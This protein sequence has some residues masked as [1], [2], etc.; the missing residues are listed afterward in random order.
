MGA[1][2]HPDPTKWFGA[3]SR[4]A[5]VERQSLANHPGGGSGG[6]PPRKEWGT[7]LSTKPQFENP[8]AVRM[9]SC[10]NA[11]MICNAS[12]KTKTNSDVDSNKTDKT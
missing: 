7:D 8:S 9:K 5:S 4:V 1:Y 11:K 2:N 3:A 10:L 12:L 6:N